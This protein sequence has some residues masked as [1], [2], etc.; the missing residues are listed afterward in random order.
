MDKLR[1]REAFIAHLDAA[2]FNTRQVAD[3]TG[4]SRD[5]MEKLRQRKVASTNVHD[6]LRI[7]R[8][9]GKTV[10]EFIG[11][12][13]EVENSDILTLIARLTPTEQEIVRA[14]LEGLLSHRRK[15]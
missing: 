3:A 7:A 15:T 11:D 5:Q 10:E 6:A 2:G 8:F 4:V 12:I 13:P 1:F 9:F 14:Q